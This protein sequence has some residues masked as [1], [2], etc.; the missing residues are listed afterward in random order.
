MN[1]F[2]E[3]VLNYICGSPDRFVNAQLTIPYDGFK[4]GSC[5]DFIV[6]DF[7]DRCV[8]VIEITSASN[9]KDIHAKIAERKTRWLIPLQEHL[10]KLRPIFSNWDYHVTVFIRG[11]ECENAQKRL[12]DQQDVSV[13]SL[14]SVV[15]PW[16][17]KW[18]NSRPV[19]PLREPGKERK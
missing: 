4:G 5:P 10:A 13:V 19:N 2:E 12:S 14:D 1:Q 15:F 7:G 6:L 17:W 11:E 3:A 18:E 9:T 8:Y 16:R